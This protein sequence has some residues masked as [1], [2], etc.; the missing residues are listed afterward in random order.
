MWQKELSAEA[1]TTYLSS[2]LSPDFFQFFLRLLVICVLSNKMVQI[3]L[4]H[5]NIVRERV[6]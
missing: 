6:F 2:D 1:S 3:V 4:Y 5:I